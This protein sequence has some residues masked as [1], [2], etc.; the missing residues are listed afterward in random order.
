MKRV[1]FLSF[2]ILSM[3]ACSTLEG[4]PTR[5]PTTSVA[6]PTISPQ[7]LQTAVELAGQVSRDRLMDDVRWLADDTRQGRRTGSPE[8]H[9][10]GVWLSSHFESLGL[11]NF[12]EAGLDSYMM[13]FDARSMQGENVIAVLRGAVRPESYVFVA[14]HYDH[15]GVSKD[16]LVYNGADDDATGV[17]AVLEIARVL[18]TARSHLQETLVFVA[19][20]GEE[21]GGFGSRS[22]CERLKAKDLV[23]RSL[24]LNLEVLGAAKGKGTFLD[25]WDQGVATTMP[26]IQGVQAMGRSIGIPVKRQGR[27]PGSDALQML[28]CGVPAISVDVAWSPEN[29]PN[30]HRLTDD[31]ESID[32]DGLYKATQVALGTAWLLANDG[33]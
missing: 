31:A 20:S 13:P 14:A 21:I 12:A 16:G 2:C 17:A 30:Y 24:M 4:R 15:I 10:V 27:D 3:I 29:H 25:A 26:I 22:L 9:V 33:L 19:F 23:R 32:V 7:P 6:L 18:S 5:T 8:E 1:L 11:V 28:D